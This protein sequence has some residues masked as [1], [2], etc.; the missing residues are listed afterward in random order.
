MILFF[1]GLMTGA[2]AG[3]M[4]AVLLS[5]NDDDDISMGHPL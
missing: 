1:A 5:A 3:L 4:I 2:A